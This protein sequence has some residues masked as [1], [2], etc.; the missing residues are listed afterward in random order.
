MTQVLLTGP[1]S[2]W[3]EQPVAGLRCGQGWVR[4]MK[5]RHHVMDFHDTL[6]L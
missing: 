5:I 6:S 1:A 3:S 2:A 4:T